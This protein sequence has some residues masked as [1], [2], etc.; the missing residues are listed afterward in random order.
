VPP[1]RHC[2]L[3]L[4]YRGLVV[5]PPTVI[6]NVGGPIGMRP[7]AAWAEVDFFF[8]YSVSLMQAERQWLDTAIPIRTIVRHPAV[9]A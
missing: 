8:S 6:V 9:D 3:S 4:T 7:A 1:E 2:R 5:I